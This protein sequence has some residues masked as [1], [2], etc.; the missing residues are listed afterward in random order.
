MDNAQKTI[1]SSLRLER[2][3][4]DKIEFKRLGFSNE[5]EVEFELESNIARRK[6]DGIYR[7]TLSLKGEKPEEY[8]FEIGLVGFFIMEDD[9]TISEEMRE[10]LITRNTVAILMPYLRSEVSLLTAQPGMDC[11]TLPIFNINHM[12]DE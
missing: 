12:M 10:K 4:F 1:Q 8:I 6:E 3:V 5:K 11:V 7:V 2:L 9:E